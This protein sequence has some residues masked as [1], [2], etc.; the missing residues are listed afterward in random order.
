MKTI[1]YHIEIV[2]VN[3]KQQ[4]VKLEAYA[5]SA[6]ELLQNLKEILDKKS[7][8]NILEILGWK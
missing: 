8:F 3:E 1:K 7:R 5:S 4:S 6:K 2:G